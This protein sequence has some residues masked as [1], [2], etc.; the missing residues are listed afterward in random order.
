MAEEK[1]IPNDPSNSNDGNK[2]SNKTYYKDTDVFIGDCRLALINSGDPDIEP[3]LTKRGYPKSIIATKLVE[4]EELAKLE[5]T[6]KKEYGDQYEATKNFVVAKEDFHEDYMD[7]LILARVAFKG[8]DA[9]QQTLE[10]NKRRKQSKDGYFAQGARFYNGILKNAD[11][12]KAMNDKGVTDAEMQEQLNEI[13][14]LIILDSKQGKEK[15][16]AQAATKKRDA[17]LHKFEDWFIDFKD[18]AIVAL[19]KS[20]QMIEKLGWIEE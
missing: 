15:A 10:L 6:Q 13:D 8:D 20:P 3:H 19:R 12:K 5:G 17:A 2:K 16:E 18:V 14:A 1:I 7:H 9:P 4:L 11:Y